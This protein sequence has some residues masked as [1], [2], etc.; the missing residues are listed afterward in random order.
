MLLLE[1]GSRIAVVGGGPAGSFFCYFLVDFASRMEL[2]IQIDVYEKKDFSKCGPKGCN[3]CGGIVSE[4]L[5]QLLATEGINLPETVVQKGIDSYVMHTDIGAVK[6]ETPLQDKRI[7]ALHRGGG[8]IGN[9]NS[10]YEGFD[11]FLQKM[12]KSDGINVIDEMV[13]AIEYDENSKIKIKCDD[14]S[15]TYDLLVGATGVNCKTLALFEQLGIGFNKP[16]TAKTFIAEFHLDAETVKKQLGNSMHVFLLDIPKLKFAALIPK[17]IYA[18]LCLLGNDIDRTLVNSFLDSPA[19]RECFP[20]GQNLLKGYSCQCFP[21]INVGS[22]KQPFG[23]RLVL[24]GDCATSKLY[25]NGI[26]AAFMTAKAAANTCIFN[27]ISELDFQRHYWPMCQSIEKDNR[28][29]KIIFLIT[30]VFKKLNITKKGLLL[31]VQSEN[32]KQGDKRRLSTIL[33][34]TFTGSSTYKSIFAK[35]LNP[36]FILCLLWRIISAPFVETVSRSGD[37]SNIDSNLLGK[38]YNEGDIIIKQGDQ[39]E[40]MYVIQSGQV[41]ILLESDGDET[42]IG[43]LGENSFFGEMALFEKEVRSATVR[44]K[45]DVRI[46]TVDKRT[47]LY[48]IQEDPSLAFKMLQKLSERIRE[49]DTIIHNFHRGNSV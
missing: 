18:T 27:G 39:G 49:M 23:N 11:Y 42:V 15:S 44:A 5:V 30:N 33:W 1:N 32:N 47:L 21:K 26:G 36:K 24:I 34:D 9:S 13:T 16:K 6:I 4:S 40:C 38:I 48:R 22:A 29:G 37:F 7:A 46:I 8:P 12:I 28:I 35:T 14:K 41:E 3:H 20:E 10:A 25:K 17:G 45:T 2:E 31:M 19:V 43:Q